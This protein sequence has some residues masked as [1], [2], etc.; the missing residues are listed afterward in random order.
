MNYNISTHNLNLNLWEKPGDTNFDLWKFNSILATT[1]ESELL[2][3]F[4][5]AHFL[6]DS[7]LFCYLIVIDKMN[8]KEI[9][10]ESEGKKVFL[11]V[12]CVICAQRLN[13]SQAKAM[14]S[15]TR[16]LSR[17]SSYTDLYWL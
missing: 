9:E 15:T 17:I 14:V 3:H 8:H 5:R 11:S 7:M 12:T 13:L 1:S 6:F 10:K 2:S 16:V 4:L